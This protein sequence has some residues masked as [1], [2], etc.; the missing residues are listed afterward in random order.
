M[1]FAEATET[2]IRRTIRVLDVRY[3]GIDIME[4]PVKRSGIE[5][6]NPLLEW[7]LTAKWAGVPWPDFQKLS[8]DEK[9]LL[10][11]AYRVNG[12]M[13]GVLARAN[14][15]KRK[16]KTGGTSRRPGKKR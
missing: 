16:P 2:G 7:V 8:S 13:D 1:G 12:Q 11:A 10:I 14:R 3:K 9:E 5:M 6:H 4:Y 15:P